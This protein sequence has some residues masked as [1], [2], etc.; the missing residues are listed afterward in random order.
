VGENAEVLNVKWYIQKLLFTKGL[1]HSM[2]EQ[3]LYTFSLY[4]CLFIPQ[5]ENSKLELGNILIWLITERE[6]ES[7]FSTSP[8]LNFGIKLLKPHINISNSLENQ[9]NSTDYCISAKK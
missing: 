1:T 6:R 8:V 5:H 7:F 4:S 3:N 2:T 9:C